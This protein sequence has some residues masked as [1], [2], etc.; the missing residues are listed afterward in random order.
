MTT[1][2][3]REAWIREQLRLKEDSAY[4]E[5]DIPVIG[6]LKFLADRLTELRAVIREQDHRVSC[7]MKP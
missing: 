6:D 2:T 3:E 7:L 4:L 5:T 1:E